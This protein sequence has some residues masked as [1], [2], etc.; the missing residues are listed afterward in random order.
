MKAEPAI[1]S[2]NLRGGDGDNTRSTGC[3]KGWVKEAHI[4]LPVI[5]ATE[6]YLIDYR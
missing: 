1:A 4:Q 5:P 2:C 6:R 3:S